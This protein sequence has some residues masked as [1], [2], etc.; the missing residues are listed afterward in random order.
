MKGAFDYNGDPDF[1]RQQIALW[2]PSD[3]AGY[4]RFMA[5]TKAIFEKGFLELADKPFLT[6]WDMLKVAP[7]LIKLQSHKTVY[8]YA[9][10]N[11]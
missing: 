6:V 9:A 1:I 8:K 7:D 2:S 4:D 10:R 11:L 5:T 3:V